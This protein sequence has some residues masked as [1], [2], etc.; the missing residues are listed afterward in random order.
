MQSNPHSAD[1]R[2]D[3]PIAV[4]GNAT[5]SSLLAEGDRLQ[6]ASDTPRLD[7][8]ILLCHVLDRPR[9]YLYTWPENLVEV[10][11]EK[12]FRDLLARRVAGE[13]V[14]HLVGYR[15]FWSLSLK[16]A[17]HTLV[18]RPETELLVEETLKRV[19]LNSA[20]VLDL[21][22]G[23]GAIAL[24]LASERPAWQLM[25]VDRVDRA[26]ALARENRQAC[27]VANMQVLQSNW[28]EQIGRLA[29]GPFDAIVSNPPYIA[30]GDSHLQQ[31]DVRFEPASALV[32]DDGGMA[33]IRLIAQQARQYLKPRGWLLLE[34][35]YQQGIAVRQLLQTFGYTE[36]QTCR[37]ITGQ[38]RVTVGCR[39]GQ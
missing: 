32:S 13:P 15:E 17:P 8:E 34:H 39:K 30:A 35:G 10:D 9:S 21:G 28:F 14:A 4:T 33:D 26:V 3:G 22:T 20:T 24:A 23:T 29:L 1:C 18:P 19:T 25:A 27:R 37:D 7:V 5:I 2:I 12:T 31:G 38:E 36:V 11:Q 6:A 16:V